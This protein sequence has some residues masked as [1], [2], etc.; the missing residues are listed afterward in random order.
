MIPTNKELNNKK[1]TSDC[2]IKKL[3]AFQLYFF[4]D[5]FCQLKTKIYFITNC[6]T[7]PFCISSSKLHTI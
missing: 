6:K 1:K 4:R 2:K 3:D 7:K 5:S